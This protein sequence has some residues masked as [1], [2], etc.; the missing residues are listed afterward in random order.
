MEPNL[1]YDGEKL[2]NWNI[3]YT[4]RHTHNFIIFKYLTT[5]HKEPGYVGEGK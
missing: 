2:E 4:H 5:N 3:C 1:T